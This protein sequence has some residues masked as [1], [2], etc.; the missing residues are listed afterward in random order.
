IDVKP[1]GP[2]PVKGLVHPVEAFEVMGAGSLRTRFQASAARG[3]A[4][5][6]GRDYELAELERALDRAREGCGQVVA[7]VGEAGVGKSRL[8]HEFARLPGTPDRARVLACPS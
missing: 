1:L 7:L 6:V 2:I 4:S 5:L 8:I 3:L